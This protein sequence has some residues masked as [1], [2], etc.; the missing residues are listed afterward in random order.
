MSFPPDVP[1]L[2]HIPMYLDS[3]CQADLLATID[4][5]P[6]LDGMRR[7]VQ[8]YG[9]RYDYSRRTVERELSLGPLPDWAAGLAERLRLDGHAPRLL[10]QLLVNEYL[11]GQGIS[12]HVDCVPCFD[13]TVVSLSLGSSC[14]MTLSRRDGTDPVDVLLQPGS[15]LIMRGDARYQRRHGIAAR[16]SDTYAGRRVL[17]GRRV[18][19]TFR[20]VLI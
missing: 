15:L 19:L 5:L 2:E 6:W 4:R 7:R 10:D 9:Y 14:L 16:K 3:H 17:R 18:S 12:P 11:P 20:T 1:G 13:E 8:Q